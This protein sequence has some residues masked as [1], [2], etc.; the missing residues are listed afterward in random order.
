MQ[1][2]DQLT[3]PFADTLRTTR[4]L[5]LPISASLP[6]L[7]RF[8]QVLTAFVLQP[9]Q[10][11]QPCSSRPLRLRSYHLCPL[12]RQQFVSFL[13]PV[14]QGSSLTCSPHAVKTRGIT[15]P[16]IVVGSALFYGGLAQL[17]AGMWEFAV[18]NTF[19]ATAFSS[20]GAFWLSYAF[21]VSP[22]SGIRA[23]YTEALDF[24]EATG[25]WLFG[26]VPLARRHSLLTLFCANRWFIYTFI[27]FLA[28]FR[29][30]IALCSVFGFLTGK[31]L[32]AL[33]LPAV[34]DA[35]RTVTFLLLAIGHFT[36]DHP[37]IL[38]AGGAFGI[39]TAFVRS[40]PC[41]LVVPS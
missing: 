24:K 37:N 6:S 15:V 4:S 19:G 31:F 17:L 20:Y 32:L 36:H 38:V 2:N 13:A 22:W 25:F 39:V 7:L 5:D 21:M 1:G 14:N 27:M 3:L 16:N 8:K 28:S 9:P 40:L 30:S 29:S 23:S 12:P 34:H 18:G 33:S 11:R 35:L 10:V 26:C 41:S